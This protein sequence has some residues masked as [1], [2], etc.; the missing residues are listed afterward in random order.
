[1]DKEAY[2]IKLQELVD[3]VKYLKSLIEDSQDEEK[4]S[5][6]KLAIDSVY[7]EMKEL[8]DNHKKIT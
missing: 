3:K 8:M 7:A 6:L 1:M 5:Y 4:I 2:Y